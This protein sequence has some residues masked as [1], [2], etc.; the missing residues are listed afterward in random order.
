MVQQVS[1]VTSDILDAYALHVH[2][3]TQTHKEVFL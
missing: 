3:H 1:V 2:T